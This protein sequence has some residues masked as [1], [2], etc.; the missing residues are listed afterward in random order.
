MLGR[1]LNLWGMGTVNV[2]INIHRRRGYEPRVNNARRVT[3]SQEGP[4]RLVVTHFI[5]I[6]L[7]HAIGIIGCMM[8]EN[9]PTLNIFGWLELTQRWP[10]QLDEE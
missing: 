10:N 2:N 3:S 1:A 9:Q 4:E 6:T 8:A 7:R 5:Y